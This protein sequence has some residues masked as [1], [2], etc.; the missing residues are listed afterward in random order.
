MKKIL[1][2]L[3]LV[4]FGIAN[5]LQAQLMSQGNKN[6]LSID[7][8]R[9]TVKNAEGLWKDYMKQFKGKTSKDKKSE[10]WFTD[11]ALVA[12]LGGANTVDLYAKFI[13][14]GEN[15]TLSFWC[16]LGGAYI[17]SKEFPD[18][19]SEAEKMLLTYGISVARQATKDLLEA[20]QKNLKKMNKNLEGLESDNKGL[21]KDIENWNAKIVKAKQDIE[22][23]VK[24]QEDTKKKIDE[25]KKLLEEIQKKLDSLR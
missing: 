6:A 19:Y 11:N 5:F 9:T 15:V 23:N 18:K 16:D 25:Q 4:A 3:A 1:T 2:T 12:G 20:E 13:Q 10:E 8:P 7:L 17:N 22:T 14:T 24:N 21:H